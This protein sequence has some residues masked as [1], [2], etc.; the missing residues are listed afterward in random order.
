[1]RHVWL[2]ILRQKWRCQGWLRQRWLHQQWRRQGLMRRMG[3]TTEWTEGC[4]LGCRGWMGE[5][6][7]RRGRKEQARKEQARA[8]EYSRHLGSFKGLCEVGDSSHR[9]W[10][11]SCRSS[12]YSD[13]CRYTG[14]TRAFYTHSSHEKSTSIRRP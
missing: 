6:E 12:L 7:C 13:R 2:Q 3:H 8:T 11:T 4:P 14:S 1:M 5:A 10:L 9:V